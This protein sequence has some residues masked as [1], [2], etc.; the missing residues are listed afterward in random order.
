MYCVYF[1][2]RVFKG[3]RLVLADPLECCSFPYNAPELQGA[4]ALVSRGG[5]SFVSKAVKAEQAGALAV[6]VMD[7]DKDNDEMYVEMVEDNTDRNPNIPAGF[8]LG[9]SGFPTNFSLY[10]SDLGPITPFINIQTSGQNFY[11]DQI[12]PAND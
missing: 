1:L 8:L 5:C 3:I 12:T 4:V 9:R 2:E 6:I 10:L 7:N 11:V